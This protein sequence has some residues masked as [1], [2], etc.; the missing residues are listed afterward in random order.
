MKKL[1][2]T[3][4]GCAALTMLAQEVL[5]PVA[6]PQPTVYRVT[7]TPV[8]TT[9]AISALAPIVRLPDGVPVA[10]V[11][12]ISAQVLQTTN[13]LVANV[14]VVVAPVAVTNAP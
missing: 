3:I 8:A 7:L 11:R 12:S 13:G 1:T 5:Q 4:I 6:P 2:L 10:R 14:T 9:A